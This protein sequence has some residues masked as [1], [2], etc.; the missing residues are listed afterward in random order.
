[1]KTGLHVFRC[2]YSFKHF[3]SSWYISILLKLSYTNLSRNVS[4]LSPNIE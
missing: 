1:M 2:D 3:V 4:R